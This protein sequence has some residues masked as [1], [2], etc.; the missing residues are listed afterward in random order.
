MLEGMAVLV[1]SARGFVLQKVG[2]TGQ[3]AVNG[4]EKEREVWN[5]HAVTS[6]PVDGTVMRV[7][8]SDKANLS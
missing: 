3:V 4:G 6:V 2:L 8:M 5:E 7:S 1:S